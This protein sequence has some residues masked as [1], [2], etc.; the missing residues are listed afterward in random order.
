MYTTALRP[1]ANKRLEEIER[2]DLI[3]GIPCSYNE[4]T[5]A[6]VI[7]Q[8]SHGLYDYFRNQRAVIFISDGGS[9]DDSR[10][11]AQEFEIKPWQEKII[12]IYRGQP[13]KGSALRAIF[14]AAAKLK[15]HAGAVVDSDL[16]SI[17]SEWI[18]HLLDPVLNR[19][20]QFVA[21]IYFRHKYDGTITNNIAYNLT[22]ALYGKRVRQPIGGA[23]A[24]S[25]DLAEAYLR[26]DVWD[27]EVAK[28]GIDIWMTTTAITRG[29][30]IAQARL[31]VKIHDVKDPGYVLGPMFKQV[32]GTLF[33]LMEKFESVWMEIRGS[34]P[35]ETFGPEGF[36]EPEPVK[37]DLKN[38]VREFR[39]GFRQFK[40]IWREIMCPE[41]FQE[42]ERAAKMDVEKVKIPMIVWI[43]AL[44][45]IAATF[46]RWKLNRKKLLQIMTP[47]YLGQV[48]S[49]VNETKNM[50][51]REAENLV[52]KQAQAFEDHKGYLIQRW[53]EAAK[54]PVDLDDLG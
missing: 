34:E 38:L 7:Q 25:R 6:R 8:V 20:C 50:N 42:I 43:Q 47:L 14:E 44:Y 30:R 12:T 16:R 10:D 53:Q 52:E 48:A 5:I 33:S 27:T 46:H 15:V 29:Y 11:V 51:S 4:K 24:F 31:G 19:D 36:Q 23:F 13:G 21:P 41:C 3:I 54:E 40:T 26:E 45:D 22:R 2:A 35:V 1:H 9:T 49:F 18:H 28:F 17:T 32:V 39:V 37:V